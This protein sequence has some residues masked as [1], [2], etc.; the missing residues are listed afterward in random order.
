MAGE[1]TGPLPEDLSNWLDRHADGRGESREAV[2]ERAVMGY[3]LAQEED[4]GDVD[5]PTLESIENFEADLS[6]VEADVSDLEANVEGLASDIEALDTTLEEQV[7]DLRE[8]VVQVLR[9]AESKAPGDHSHEEVESAVAELDAS[10]ED[11]EKRLDDLSELREDVAD[12]A[13]TT[14]EANRKLTTLA[15]AAVRLQRRM[16]T[17]ERTVT[18]LEA[19]SDIKAVANRHGIATADCESCGRGVR[20]GLLTAPR[21]PHCEQYLESVVPASGFLGSATLEVGDRPELEGDA[22]EPSGRI[23]FVD[24]V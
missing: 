1:Q 12:L 15:N 6:T 22:E 9:E 24:D 17:V 20:V 13:E 2:L 8:R 4:G 10:V 18:P 7:T 5:V 23:D 21:C 3:R 11:V 16:A 19:V 14:E